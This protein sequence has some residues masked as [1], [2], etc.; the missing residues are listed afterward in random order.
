MSRRLIFA[1]A[2]VAFGLT[3]CT[4]YVRPTPPP[5]RVEIKPAKPYVRAAWVPGHWKWKNRKVRYVWV[6]GHWKRY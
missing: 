5:T 1:L 4:A 2:I 3:G 6:P